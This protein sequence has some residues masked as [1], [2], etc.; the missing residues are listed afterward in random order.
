M[1]AHTH[2]HMYTRKKKNPTVTSKGKIYP[3]SHAIKGKKKHYINVISIKLHQVKPTHI[4]IYVQEKL[5]QPNI[6]FKN[7]NFPN[8][9]H[10]KRNQKNTTSNL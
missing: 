2:M 6:N 1:L 9:N 10:N 5:Q 8:S 7:Q 3:I 4:C